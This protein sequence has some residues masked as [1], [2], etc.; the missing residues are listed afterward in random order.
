MN[1]QVPPELPGTKTPT[2]GCIHIVG[3]MKTSVYVAEGGLVSH[4]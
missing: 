3:L 4:Q 2:K 1:Y